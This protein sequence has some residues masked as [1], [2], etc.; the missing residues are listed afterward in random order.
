MK[1]IVFFLL[2][3]TTFLINA[4]TV[5][6][7]NYKLIIEPKWRNLEPNVSQ[8]KAFGGKWVVVGSITFKKKGKEFV[9]LTRLGL[10][11]KGQPIDLLVASLY[12]K[13]ADQ[14]FKPI[15]QN[16][17]CDGTWNKAKQTLKLTFDHKQ[18]IGLENI[19]YLVLTIPESLESIVKQGSFEILPQTL[20]E[21]FRVATAAQK[22]SLSLDAID[23]TTREWQEDL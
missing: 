16:L 19:F 4:T 12:R 22:L 20:P 13:Y 10:Q 18:S 6:S 8:A 11:W 23:T 3:F 17:V 15:E 21:P 2:F 14:E 5:E 7:E 9:D 1:R